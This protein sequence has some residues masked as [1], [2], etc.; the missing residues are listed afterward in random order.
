M[1]TFTIYDVEVQCHDNEFALFN[2]PGNITCQ[3]Y[4][5]DYL[6]GAGSGANLVNPNATEACKVC[7][8][9]KGSDYL[10]TINLPDYIDG[11]R[12]AGIVVIFVFSSY[13][14]VYLL[15]KLRTK[16]SKKAQ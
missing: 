8:Y 4:L 15:M 10:S 13:A 2:T 5:A 12:D 16:A 7:Q 6:M 11:W 3:D 1:L 9:K 14:M